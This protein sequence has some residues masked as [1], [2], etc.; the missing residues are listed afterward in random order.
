MKEYDEEFGEL[1]TVSEISEIL[2]VT[3][4]M[5]NASI[6][7][8]K[9]QRLTSIDATIGNDGEGRKISDIIPD[10]KAESPEEKLDKE[11]ISDIISCSLSRLSQREEQVMRMRFGIYNVE[12]EERFKI[13][14]EEEIAIANGEK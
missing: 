5:V 6:E 2:G 4:D 11:K 13:S 1:P 3:E 10:E 14:A 8:M 12:N 7:A 9:L